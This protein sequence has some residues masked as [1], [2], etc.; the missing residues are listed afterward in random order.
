MARIGMFLKTNKSSILAF[1]IFNNALWTL[2]TELFLKTRVI[3]MNKL[4]YVVPWNSVSEYYYDIPDSVSVIEELLKHQMNNDPHELYNF[5][6]SLYYL[7]DKKVPK[8]NCICVIGP[9]C[10]GKIFFFFTV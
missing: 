1:T 2:R 4:I 5:L 3:S 8:K 6:K 9:S 7:I 10:S